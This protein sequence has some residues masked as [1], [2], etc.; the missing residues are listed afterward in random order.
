MRFRYW[1][2][3][4]TPD[5]TRLMT[6]GVGIL[7][8]D[9]ENRDFRIHTIDRLESIPNNVSNRKAILSAAQSISADFNKMRSHLG[10]LDL[11]S[12]ES[13][14]SYA[15]QLVSHWNNFISIDKPRSMSATNINEAADL[16][17]RLYI[18]DRKS[19]SRTQKITRLR[20]AVLETYERFPEIERNLY[21]R[22]KVKVDFLDGRFD[23]AVVR[24]DDRVFEL[25]SSFTFLTQQI[26]TNRDRIESWNYR[27]DRIRRH[28]G[29]LLLG[30]RTVSIDKTTPIVVTY[31][32]PRTSQQQ[33]IYQSLSQQWNEL[34][35]VAVPDHE[36]E[37]HSSQL[38]S[39]ILA[40]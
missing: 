30:D 19:T 32:P 27:V 6:F 29:N 3:Q 17:F 14:A 37:S 15:S 16:L 7:V 9:A 38:H 21:D 11:P 12:S 1:T 39:N 18:E 10:A 13:P 40:A 28:G 23:L 22:P 36:L 2:I 34:D 8:M 26:Q 31:D 33:E 20:K 35:V 4:A 5:P 24:E 25:N